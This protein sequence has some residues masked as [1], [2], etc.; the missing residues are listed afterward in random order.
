MG[1]VGRFLGGSGGPKNGGVGVVGVGGSGRE[2]RDWWGWGAKRKD[3]SPKAT[4][5][6]MRLPFPLRGHV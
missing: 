4:Q 3:D 6:R 1:G 5:E 2:G